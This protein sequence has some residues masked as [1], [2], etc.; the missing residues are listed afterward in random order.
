MLAALIAMAALSAVPGDTAS[1]GASWV[2]FDVANPDAAGRHRLLSLEDLLA[3]RRAAVHD[4]PSAR[5]VLVFATTLDD[6]LRSALVAA[7]DLGGGRSAEGA[8]MCAAMAALAR[9]ARPQGGLVIGLLLDAEDRVAEA[10]G[11]LPA[12]HLPFP[13]A[14]DPRGLVR[15]VLGLRRPGEALVIDAAGR[16]TRF[17]A[18]SGGAEVGGPAA[19]EGNLPLL[20]EVRRG[21]LQGL[22]RDKED[23]E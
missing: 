8:G 17:P 12:A 19:E 22:V 20:A 6:C 4:L 5:A 2:V 10:R 16:M 15:S 18:G 11:A 9:D 14:T 21:F 23:Q 7:G 3:A 13:V 1:E